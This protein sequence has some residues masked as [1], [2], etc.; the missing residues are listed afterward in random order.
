MI[1]SLGNLPRATYEKLRQ[2]AKADPLNSPNPFWT[3]ED[4]AGWV[5][6]HTQTPRQAK[7]CRQF[8][9]SIGWRCAQDKR[10]RERGIV[11]VWT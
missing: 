11:T 6:R 5:R 3:R 10:N 2:V 7:R 4:V 9:E 8:A 1:G